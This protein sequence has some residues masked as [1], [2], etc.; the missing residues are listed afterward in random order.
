MAK[1]CVSRR[2][3]LRV[4]ALLILAGLLTAVG[5]TEPGD[6]NLNGEIDAG[7]IPLIIDHITEVSPLAGEALTNADANVDGVVDIADAV[8]DDLI[9]FFPTEI[10][11]SSP[12]N[13]EDGVAVTRETIVHFST[14]LDASTISPESVMAIFAGEP[15][16][17]AYN[18]SPDG[19]TLTI[20]YNETAAWASSTSTP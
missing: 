15:L 13:G 16:D 7:D 4:G 1:S 19:K 12:A 14:P 8:T 5:P 2:G 6:T 10:V 20:F 9:V 11:R 18:L 17:T 3:H